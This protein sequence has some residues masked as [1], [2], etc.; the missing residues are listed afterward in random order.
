MLRVIPVLVLAILVVGCG[1]GGEDLLSRAIAA[2]TPPGQV[3]YVEGREF[4]S[5]GEANARSVAVWIDGDGDLFRYERRREW[6]GGSEIYVKVGEGWESTDF[7]ESA[8]DVDEESVPVEYQAIFR[9]PASLALTYLWF[10]ATADKWQV[11]ETR[12]EQERKLV[13]LEARTVRTGDGGDFAA[14]TEFIMTIMLEADTLWPVRRELK[15]IYPNGEEAEESEIVEFD[16]VEL[17][18]RDELPAEFFSRSA[19]R[20]L[21]QTLDDKIQEAVSLDFTL[22]WLGESDS[23]SGLELTDVYVTSDMVRVV[24]YYNIESLRGSVTIRQEKGDRQSRSNC[25]S[26]TADTEEVA[27]RGGKA[28]LETSRYGGHCLM[29]GLDGTAVEI[30]TVPVGVG[31]ND[32]NAFNNREA[33][34]ALAEGLEPAE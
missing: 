4:P 24:L 33:I 26:S 18:A 32:A 11:L 2:V 31:G 20:E 14:G 16:R 22:Y 30:F 6:P 25:E 12:I 29:F 13:V 34:V 28:T 17:L 3:F 7:E 5:G 23:E 19:V 9:D 10:L 15:I 21:F 27:V 1:D 8:N